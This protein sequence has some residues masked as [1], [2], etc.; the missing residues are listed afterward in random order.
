MKTRWHDMA[1][2][3]EG[4]LYEAEMII[5]D[6]YARLALDFPG[7]FV[8]V[9]SWKGRS[10]VILAGVLADSA[11]NK[12]LI[13]IDPHEGFLGPG[14]DRVPAGYTFREFQANLAKTGLWPH[15]ICVRQRAEDYVLAHNQKIALLFLD[16]LH[17]TE[18]VLADLNKFAPHVTGY[19]CIH[20]YGKPEF[21]V[22]EA[23]HRFLGQSSGWRIKAIP[24]THSSIL[25][26]EKGV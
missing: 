25:V 2:K 23:V 13:C 19:I 7:D 8:E 6:D 3:I 20:D 4:W 9:G 5:L 10:T 11:C 12:K 17:D 26:L 14:Y 21:G 24:D 1:C 15:V 16:G 22:T 18:H